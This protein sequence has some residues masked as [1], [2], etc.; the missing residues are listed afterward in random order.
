MVEF[1]GV[2]GCK[3]LAVL[4]EQVQLMT[5]VP[6]DG[7]SENRADCHKQLNFGIDQFSVVGSTLIESSLIAGAWFEK[8]NGEHYRV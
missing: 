8:T 6:V 2:I 5:G 4:S 7:P 3:G 1:C